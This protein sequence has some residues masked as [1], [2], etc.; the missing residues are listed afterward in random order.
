MSQK[1]SLQSAWHI[2][3]TQSGKALMVIFSELQVCC[4]YINEIPTIKEIQPLT[5][6]KEY[7]SGGNM[8]TKLWKWF[9][10][11]FNR[12]KKKKPAK[13]T[14]TIPDVM[15]KVPDDDG[16]RKRGVGWTRKNKKLSKTRRLM[17]KE[18]RRINRRKK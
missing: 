14:Y 8:I 9:I 17:A 3:L 16:K 12:P 1:T 6:F 10:G 4:L 5:N 13:S 2:Q 11:L 18:S 15:V 7:K